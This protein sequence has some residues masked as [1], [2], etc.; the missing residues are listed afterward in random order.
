MPANT[1]VLWH[2]RRGPDH[3]AQRTHVLR[4]RLV[5]RR[6]LALANAVFFLG[7]LGLWPTPAS[8][9]GF[10]VERVQVDATAADANAAREVALA[11]G[12]RDAFRVL[13]QRLVPREHHGRL[14]VVRPADL[15]ALVFSLGIENE[16]T[17][18]T[19]YLANLVVNFRKDSVR[20]LLLRAQIPF[21]ETA[22]RPVLVLPVYNAAGS[23][24]LW[25]D[26]N[27]WWQ[28]WGIVRTRDSLSPMIMANGD[29]TDVGL[30]SA[31]QAIGG[32][33]ARLAAIAARHGVED[34]LVAQASLR[35][36]IGSR[37]PSIDVVLRYFG[38]GGDSTTVEAFRGDVQEP[39]QALLARAAE[40]IVTGVEE[41]W[42]RD[43]LLAF[44]SEA[45]LSA[46]VP[47]TGLGEWVAVRRRLEQ[48]PEI[49][50]VELAEIS[51]S[52]AQVVLH[53]FGE[54]GHLAVAL[55]QRGLVL[56]E[57]NGFWTLK[58]RPGALRE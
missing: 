48:A 19:R 7:L 49:K 45:A 21:A 47:L 29:F 9:D 35:F 4:Q 31:A 36:E 40:I 13:M 58:L 57:S 22:R 26:P 25:D 2:T 8:A 54:A 1:P 14:P 5:F 37:I 27:P 30:I 46:T 52:S 39:L 11:N 18:P 24:L 32:D 44:G 10:V 42:K 56:A 23:Q 51:I 41:R 55:A 15:T 20:A 3:S 33:R 53:Y 34:V 12:T 6:G 17:S 38:P 50:T 16:R 43:N 28:A